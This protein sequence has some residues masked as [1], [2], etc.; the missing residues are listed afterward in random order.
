M[1]TSNETNNIFCAMIKA[2]KTIGN[3]K[4]SAK[5][6]GYNYVPIEDIIDHLKTVLP[7]LGL[8]YSQFPSG[9]DGQTIGITTIVFHESGEWISDTGNFPT[10]S[11]EKNSRMNL[12]QGIGA[13]ITYARR[14]SLASV[15]GITGEEDTDG[16]TKGEETAGVKNLR[17]LALDYVNKQGWPEA[18]KQNIIKSINQPGVNKGYL[19]MV[20]EGRVK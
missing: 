2:R 5:G 13:A 1:K 3:L 11:T 16:T 17:D 7:P 20:I 4:P 10:A 12:V 8:G 9:G 14:Y 6:H 19:E 18:K 15:F